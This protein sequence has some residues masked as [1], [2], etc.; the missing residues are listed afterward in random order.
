[1]NQ[2]LIQFDNVNKR[3][4]DH[5]VLK[6]VCLRVFK[7]E[8]TT[9]IGKS[10]VGKSVLLKHIIGLMEP[11]SGQILFNGEPMAAMKRGERRRLERKFSYMFQ[12]SALF[13][14]MTVY[15]NVALPLKEKSR[16]KEAEIEKRVLDKLEALDLLNIDE[17]YPSQLSGGMKKRVALAR[18]LITEPEIVLFDEPTTGLDPIRKNAVHGMISEYQKKFGFTGVVVSHEIPDIFYISQRVA[19]LEEG[20]IFAE[21]T[22]AEIQDSSDPVVQNFIHGLMAPDRETTGMESRKACEVHFLQERS[23]LN[24]H[25]TP[26]SVIVFTFDNIDELYEKTG[27]VGGQNVMNHFIDMLRARLRI[28]DTCCRYGLNRVVA[29]MD[30]VDNESAGRLCHRLA[31]E[32]TGVHLAIAEPGSDKCFRISAGIADVKAE[33]NL[34]DAVTAAIYR[35]AGL[36]EF[37]VCE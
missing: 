5:N 31:Q 1:M 36:Y 7:G 10:G 19:M 35:A 37:Q 32:M 22:P 27:H 16:L 4:G 33:G 34:E 23:R 25:G 15:E 17:K 28:T 18:A 11:D 14:S 20:S 21:G 13:D 6:G 29:I 30:G 3:F 2:P 8:I 9:I 12:G 24:R 26:F